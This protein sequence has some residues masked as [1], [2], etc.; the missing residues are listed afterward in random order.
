MAVSRRVGRRSQGSK[1]CGRHAHRNQSQ[2]AVCDSISELSL[3]RLECVG[4]QPT[5]ATTVPFWRRQA[6][7]PLFSRGLMY[8]ENS[9]PRRN[10]LPS[11][12]DRPQVAMVVGLLWRRDASA[13]EAGCGVSAPTCRLRRPSRSV[14]VRRWR[15]QWPRGRAIEGLRGTPTG[16]RARIQADGAQ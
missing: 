16:S 12:G 2:P 1:Q 4:G 5:L 11:G 15:R 9:R 6:A 13:F 10:A 3:Q 7:T 14:R 8:S